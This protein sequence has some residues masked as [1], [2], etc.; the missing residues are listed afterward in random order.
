M[1]RR[2]L[3]PAP[4]GC[5]SSSRRSRRTDRIVRDDR[6]E[7]PP[8]RRRRDAVAETR[9]DSAVTWKSAPGRAGAQT[10]NHA[11]S[12]QAPPSALAV[13]LEHPLVGSTIRG[14]AARR[15]RSMGRIAC[16]PRDRPNRRCSRIRCITFPACRCAGCPWVTP[17]GSSLTNCP[18]HRSPA[19]R[20][21]CLRL[22]HNLQHGPV[23]RR[24][25]LNRRCFQPLRRPLPRG[26]LHD[27]C[28]GTGR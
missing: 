8:E 7:I 28:P 4:R 14:S 17:P 11:T 24:H 16:R 26:R 5:V 6:N 18:S 23:R 22:A 25:Q 3:E 2:H 21:P 27:G 1:H 15:F 13:V 19:P 20:R 10:S 9:T 12:A